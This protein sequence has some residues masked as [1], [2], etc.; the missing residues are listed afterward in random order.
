MIAGWNAIAAKLQ[1]QGEIA[2]GADVRCF[3]MH[4]PPVRTD[5]ERPAA[6]LGQLR[7]NSAM[8]QNGFAI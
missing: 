3:A 5:R 4:L 2:L 7:G 1:A 6:H 8:W